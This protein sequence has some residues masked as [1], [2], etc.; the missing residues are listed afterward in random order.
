M[1]FCGHR[2]QL[3]FMKDI[4]NDIF[5]AGETIKQTLADG[6]ELQNMSK[7]MAGLAVPNATDRICE[8]ILSLIG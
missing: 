8:I 4:M 2:I 1:T 5:A 7:A 6:D 3:M